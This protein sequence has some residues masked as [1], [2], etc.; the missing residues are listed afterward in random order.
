M[1]TQTQQREPRRWRST[2]T[3]KGMTLIEIMVVILIL[4]LIASAVGT[5]VFGIFADSKVNQARN[6][7]ANM[8]DVI[9]LVA[10]QQGSTPDSLEEV[11]QTGKLKNVAKGEVPLDPWSR[12]YQYEKT[13]ETD[14]GFVLWSTGAEES[15]ETDDIRSDELNQT[16]S[17][18]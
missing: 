9:Q 14:E 5:N 6:E 13:T 12:P 2:T 11:T 4:G 3:Q 15:D 7:I 16:R 8:K 10:Q 18:R 17:R 1:K